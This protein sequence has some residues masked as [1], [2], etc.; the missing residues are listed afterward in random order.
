MSEIKSTLDLVMERTKNLTLSEAEKKEQRKTDL[1]KRLAGLVQKYQDQTIKPTELF[2]HLNELKNT[3]GQGVE[4]RMA[5]EILGHIDVETDND[6]C[7]ALLTD[8]FGLNISTLKT[9]QAEF[10]QVLRA[11]K[12]DRIDILKS[13]LSDRY[14]ISG[15]A[16]IPN[17]ETDPDWQQERNAITER[18]RIQ[19]EIEKKR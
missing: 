7:L 8:Y 1:K 17:I 15:T 10:K 16:V 13:R 4:K 18:F 6:R 2:K 11:G 19:L 5:D 9:V 14:G 12:N 3:F